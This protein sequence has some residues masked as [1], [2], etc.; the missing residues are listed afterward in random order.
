LYNEVSHRDI[1]VSHKVVDFTQSCV[2]IH[3]GVRNE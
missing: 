3:S 2:K 1:T